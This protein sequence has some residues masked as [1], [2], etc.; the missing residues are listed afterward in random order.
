M[1]TFFFYFLHI[2]YILF[3]VSEGVVSTLKEK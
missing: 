1:E 3:L 2:V